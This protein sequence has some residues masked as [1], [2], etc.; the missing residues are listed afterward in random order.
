MYNCAFI[1]VFALFMYGGI[2]FGFWDTTL[3]ISMIGI[4]MMYLVIARYCIIS[5]M[6]E[7][8]AICP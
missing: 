5:M 1:F 7:N 8:Q 6:S 3:Y 4:C 2:L